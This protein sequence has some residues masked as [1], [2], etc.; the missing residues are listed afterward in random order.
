MLDMSP[1]AI[2]RAALERLIGERRLEQYWKKAE[3]LRT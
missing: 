2:D 3:G 1:D